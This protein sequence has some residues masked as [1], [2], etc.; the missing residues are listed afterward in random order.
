MTSLFP[1]LLRA[2]ITD[3]MLVLLISTMAT[4]KYKNKWIY[5]FVTTII[6]V[7]N[8]SANCYYYFTENYNAVFFVDLAMLLIIGIGL[9]PLF[10]DKI[11]QWCFSYITMINV[12]MAIVFLSYIL[13]DLFPS[14]LYGI[15]YLRLILFS[16]IIYVFNKCITKA[17][18][19]VL[20]NWYIYIVPTILLMA[21]FLVY[22]FGGDIQEMLVQ[23]ELPLIFLILLG[24]SV[25]V[26][27]IHSLNSTTNQYNMREENHKMQTEREYLQLAT[28]DMAYRLELMEEV[29]AQNS[30][31][32]HDRRHFNNVLLELLNQ[33]ENNEVMSLLG[34]DNQ[35]ENKITK[36]Y[37]ENHTVNAAVSHYTKIADQANIHTEIIL[38]IPNDL[39]IDSLELSMVVSNLM[40][41]AIQVCK[42]LPNNRPPYIRFI[43]RSV[44]RL[45]L[46]IENTCSEDARLDQNGFP[47]AVEAGHGIGSKSIIAFAK[48]YD[49]ELLYKIENG[50]FQV[51]LLV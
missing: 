46:E 4:P 6:V 43:S 40:E 50:V 2:I 12:Y 37:C 21:C 5:F 34:R 28:R 38:D 13:R 33:G 25:Y 14:P 26:S 49:G 32:A 29:S 36:I 8:V 35:K 11:M 23:N 18:R 39:D 16:L 44:G 10:R 3:I 48:K 19:K 15:I 47:I 20:D 31:E 22:F 45:L 30:R 27:I 9:K 42:K 17:Y 7:G 1:N 41:N 24:I 51:R